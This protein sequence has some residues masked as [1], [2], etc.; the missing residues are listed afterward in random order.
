MPTPGFFKKFSSKGSS[1]DS[2][3]ASPDATPTIRPGE[4]PPETPAIAD[5][6]VPQYSDAM[7]E[8]WSAANTELPRARGAE[9]FLN[10]VGTS[11][12]PGPYHP[13]TDIDKEKVQTAVTLT[14]GQ[15]AVVDTLVVPVKALLDTPQIADT[16]EKGVNAFMEAVP[17][18]MSALDEVAK[19]HPFISGMGESVPNTQFL[20]MVS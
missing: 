17:V 2:P 11:I 9:K 5:P 12:V 8:A 10:N 19:I 6:S 4:I 16:I 1:N 7:K 18:L 15:Q 14:D 20:I 3:D 13:N